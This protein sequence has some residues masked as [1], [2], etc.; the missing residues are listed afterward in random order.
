MDIYCRIL[1]IL[2]T[3]S[4]KKV[5]FP[6][7]S[8]YQLSVAL[9]RV[10]TLWPTPCSMVWLFLS[11]EYSGCSC[12]LSSVSSYVQLPSSAP[13]TL[14]PFAHPPPLA[15]I[16]LFLFPQWSLGPGRRSCEICVPFSAEHS[17]SLMFWML[18]KCESLC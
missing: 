7:P 5:T 9:P 11:W 12:C 18:T 15:L 6:F 8:N 1:H 3:K 2:G 14:F 4:L 17:K 10:G 16:I 13:G